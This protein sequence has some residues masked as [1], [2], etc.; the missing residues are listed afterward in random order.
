[1]VYAMTDHFDDEPD[2]TVP[3]EPVEPG[4]G[5]PWMA[6]IAIVLI[7]VVVITGLAGFGL[8]LIFH[9]SDVTVPFMSPAPTTATL[10]TDNAAELAVIDGSGNLS[11]MDAAGGSVVRHDLTDVQFTFPAWSPDGGRIAATGAGP[12]GSGVYVVPVTPT[13]GSGAEA[14]SS[15][16]PS[17]AAPDVTAR[18]PSQPTAV[19]LSQQRPAFYVYW[20]PNSRSIGFLS[21]DPAGSIQL[22][23]SPADGSA[24]AGLVRQGS[25]MYWAWVDDATLF[26]HAGGGTTAFLGEVGPTGDP[27]GTSDPIN[28]AGD[29]RAPA[30]SAGGDF[31]AY[32]GRGADHAPAIIVEPRVPNGSPH[33]E[34]KV[35]GPAAVVFDPAGDRLAFI[36]RSNADA[37]QTDLPV[38]PLKVIDAHSSAVRTLLPGSVIG[39][40]WSPDGRSIAAL[41]LPS[42]GTPG[43]AQAAVFHQQGAPEGRPHETPRPS[44]HPTSSRS[45]PRESTS[46]FCSSIRRMERSAP[47]VRSD[48]PTSSPTRCSR[49]STSTP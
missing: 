42:S 9:P 47:S 23:L 12:S 14:G 17:A 30:V 40:F 26:V 45:R 13:P 36:A 22:R 37:P 48:S 5:R 25:P 43:T 21:S 49:T 19:Y 18:D 28:S 15:N 39:F 16:A 8:P 33:T 1:M 46:S 41:R 34:A 20:T 44:C 29:F 27:A 11:T 3:I 10:P 2:F 7:V 24:Q 6:A 38:G 35:L 31:R 32:A 4:R